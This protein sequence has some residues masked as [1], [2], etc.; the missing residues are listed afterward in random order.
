M[1][2]LQS[3]CLAHVKVILDTENNK[4]VSIPLPLHPM[5]SR[6]FNVLEPLFIRDILPESGHGLLASKENWTALLSTLPSAANSIVKT[7][8]SH[9][10]ENTTSSPKKKWEE[11]KECIQQF[12]GKKDDS[13]DKK[14]KKLMTLTSDDKRKIEQWPYETVFRFT[15]PRL[16]I[17]VSKMQNH[18]LKA[19][20]CVHPKTGRVCVPL[21]LQK[22]DEFDPFA[23]PTLQTVVTELD[24]YV[25]QDNEKVEY[26]WQ[27]TS[28]KKYFDHFNAS[29]LIPMLKTVKQSEKLER[30]QQASL[31][32]DF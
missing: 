11:I 7:L 4:N 29:F 24:E 19:P 18:L 16:D 15:Y 6:A 28:L 10:D 13:E 14:K 31:A 21:N 26:E 9:W 32:A 17:N 1:M 12:V 27:K 2:K 22:I 30:E 8:L 25:E 23:V 20:F 5:L 3:H